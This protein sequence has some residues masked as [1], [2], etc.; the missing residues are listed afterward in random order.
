MCRFRVCK[1]QMC[2]ANCASHPA[3][4]SFHDQVHTLLTHSTGQLQAPGVSAGHLWPG[5][6]CHHLHQ[7]QLVLWVWT[8]V[9]LCS[10]VL[11][12]GENTEQLRMTLLILLIPWPGAVLILQYCYWYGGRN[13]T[14]NSWQ[15]YFYWLCTGPTNQVSLEKSCVVGNVTAACHVSRV[16]CH[17]VTLSL[18]PAGVV[19]AASLCSLGLVS[20]SAPRSSARAHPAQCPSL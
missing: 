2:S 8:A 9:V 10:V 20:V 6:I 7:L 17:W 11:G 14:H 13:S 19:S 18:S 16:T 5:D 4:C 15:W 3:N 12:C 1:Y